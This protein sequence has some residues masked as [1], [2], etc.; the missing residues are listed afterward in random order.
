MV[1][2][3]VQIFTLTPSQENHINAI[4]DANKPDEW[5][6]STIVMDAIRSSI[7]DQLDLIQNQKCCYCGLQLW[8]TARG[9]IDHIAPKAS[10]QA[11]YPEF[12]FVKQNLALSCEYCNGSSKKGETNVV[13]RYNSIY[14]DCE[15][16]IVHPYFDN[17]NDHYEWINE[18]TKI[19]VRHKSWK[20][21]YSIILFGLKE[22]ANAR[23]KQRIYEKKLNRIKMIDNIINRFNTIINFRK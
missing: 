6:R 23:A 20:G 13:F 1:N 10:R 15:F 16:K 21:K 2:Q 7:K 14:S 3:I 8:E 22:L 19:V 18:S 12:T 17:P 9:E 11:A 4:P 5:K